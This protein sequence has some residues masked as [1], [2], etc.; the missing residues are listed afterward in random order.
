LSAFA[1]STPQFPH[2]PPRAS[3]SSATMDSSLLRIDVH[4]AWVGTPRSGSGSQIAARKSPIASRLI[5]RHR[6]TPRHLL[7]RRRGACH[8]RQ[9]DDRA[10]NRRGR[11]HAPRP[12]TVLPRAR[13]ALAG[14]R[15]SGRS[16][17]VRHLPRDVAFRGPA[18]RNRSLPSGTRALSAQRR[19]ARIHGHELRGGRP[20]RRATRPRS[21]RPGAREGA[22]ARA[23]RA[24]GSDELRA[25]RGRLR[26][27]GRPAALGAPAIP[28]SP[29][30]D[31][32]AHY[33]LDEPRAQAVRSG[34]RAAV[35]AASTCERR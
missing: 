20:A 2:P 4:G 1:G 28:G 29:R 18:R 17:A 10:R 31:G 23:R 24:G 9:C 35:A 21:G 30:C 5:H 6:R 25:R 19:D 11:D 7:R 33:R 14:A 22:G 32:Q 12:W 27:V 16:A 8:R 34:V 3:W 13:C 15:P 26:R